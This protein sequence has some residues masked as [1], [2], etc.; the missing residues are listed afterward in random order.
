MNLGIG[1]PSLGRVR[2]IISVLVLDYGFGYVL[3]QLGV[4][5]VLPLGRRRGVAPRYAGLSGPERLRLAL[6]E[7]GP[8]FI[9]LG[10]LLSAR[11]DLLPPSV[12][13]ELRRLQDEAPALPFDQ[14]R[15]VIESELGRPVERIFARLDPVP[16]SAASLGQ[17]HSG[18]LPDGRE[19]T[20]K[21]QRPEARR[22]VEA[23]LQILSELARLLHRQLPA[24]QMHDL[25]GLVRHF[26]YQLQDELNYT[27]EGHNADRLRR[28]LSD[29]EARVR[30]PEVFWALTT[31]RLLTM[32]HLRGRRVDRLADAVFDRPGAARRL[33]HS[34]LHQMLIDGFFHGDPHQGNVLF[35][36][37][38][39]ILMLDFG[40]MGFLDPRHRLLLGELV[41]HVYEEDVDQVIDTMSELATLGPEA[42]LASLR[43][44]LAGLLSRFLTLPRRDLPLGEMLIRML[45]ALW[46]NHV[47]VARELSL[48]TKAVLMTEAICTELDPEFDFRELAQ[49]VI[50]E[51]RAQQLRGRALYQRASRAVESTTRRLG[52]V[53]GRVDRIMSLMEQGGLRVRSE[54]PAADQR[55][56]GLARAIHRLA[57]C[58]LSAAL[59]VS[60]T[61]YVSAARHPAHVGVGVAAA[62]AGVT[63]G[64]IALF[65]LLRPGRI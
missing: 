45:R 44:E 3:E 65:A 37:E 6:A 25:P 4:G 57:L 35:T 5:R 10:Q 15:G 48:A 20:V 29:T 59:L 21:V 28:T 46:L 38:G 62:A 63:L 55:W 22:V 30:I 27:Q 14:I 9:K 1:L 12:V 34:L 33:G 51:A 52:R 17:V 26:A 2:K 39:E 58:I 32:E 53:P 61:I 49:P 47:K 8:T 23:D 13:T 56:A 43:T 42:D 64:L 31:R 50:E 36:A 18:L 54:D 7:L 11:A 16:L 19:V 41:S 60:S 24:L 40:I